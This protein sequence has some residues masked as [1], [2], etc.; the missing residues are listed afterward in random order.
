MRLAA[1]LADVVLPM[2]RK[3]RRDH[4]EEY[5]RGLLMDGERKSIEPIASRLPDGNVQA[6]QQLVNQSPWSSQKVRA[7]L[8]RKVEQ[9]FVPE[10]YWMIDD[11]SF[12]KQG[13]HSVGVARQYCGALGKTANCQ[14]AVT[15]D[16]GTEEASTPLNWALYLPEKWV[17]D[18]V[19]RKEAG[20]PEEITFKTKPELALGLIDEAIAWGLQK[21]LV[22]TDSGYGDVYEFRQ[23]LRS[24]ELDYVVQ[25][26]KDLTAWTED[27]HPPEP[28][29]KGGEKSPGNAIMRTIFLSRG[30]WIRS[31]KACLP[32]VGER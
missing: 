8:A 13:D 10:A 32:K 22:L 21:R 30:A 3:E 9:E 17:K 27:P 15:L 31:P 24:R 14:V 29:M 26:S 23:A 12:P 18:S 1:F 20:V 19:R 6:L 5:L 25:V 7:S 11:V 28:P 16:L 4:A 2:G